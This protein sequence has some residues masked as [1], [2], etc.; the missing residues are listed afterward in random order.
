MTKFFPRRFHDYC[1]IERGEDYFFFNIC[2]PLK[3]IPREENV[4]SARLNVYTTECF[5][6]NKKE[7]GGAV[8]NRTK[9]L[10]IIRLNILAAAFRS[11]FKSFSILALVCWYQ[12]RKVPPAFPSVLFP[13]TAYKILSHHRYSRHVTSRYGTHFPGSISSNLLF[14]RTCRCST[15]AKLKSCYSSPSKSRSQDH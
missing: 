1:F 11:R 12:G 8:S 4:V 9:V 14:P 13:A 5:R 7:I 2:R 6:I 10:L 3:K 15:G